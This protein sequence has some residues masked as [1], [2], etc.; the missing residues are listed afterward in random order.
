MSEL[1]ERTE[2]N[3]KVRTDIF[4]EIE[5]VTFDTIQ[6][7]WHNKKFWEKEYA[8]TG[9]VESVMEDGVRV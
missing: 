1:P 4:N 7:L 5:M 8:V 6:I 3:D 2:A 9:I